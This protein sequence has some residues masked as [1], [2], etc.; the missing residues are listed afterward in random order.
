MRK[1]RGHLAERLDLT[2]V[3]PKWALTMLVDLANA[4][5]VD[6]FLQKWQF[7][8]LL[9]LTQ[10]PKDFDQ[11]R[12]VVRKVWRGEASGAAEVSRHL[13]FVHDKSARHSRP[14]LYVDWKRS[15][16]YL[17]AS[18]LNDVVWLTL[19]RYSQSLGVC[20]NVESRENPTGTCVTPY[21]IKYRPQNQFCS[22]ICAGPAHRETKR[23]W[24]N[25]K[26]PGGLTKRRGGRGNK[27]KRSTAKEK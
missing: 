7:R 3:L 15:N 11:L 17:S 16:L 26:G 9:S 22:E 1:A 18:D 23:R 13:G 2:I 24:W 8:E 27:N 20:G 21:F 14:P 6:F 19:L 25:E 12:A 4:Q 5:S 10:E